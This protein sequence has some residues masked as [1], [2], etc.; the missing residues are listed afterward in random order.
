MLIKS[1][2]ELWL[3]SLIKLELISLKTS[4]SCDKDLLTL[5]KFFSINFSSYIFVYCFLENINTFNYI[6]QYIICYHF[7]KYFR[8][9]IFMKM[10]ANYILQYIIKCHKKSSLIMKIKEN[11]R[12]C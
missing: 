7:H 11:G 8:N 10:I 1:C 12:E 5:I 2:S 6:L 4:Q 3:F 9:I